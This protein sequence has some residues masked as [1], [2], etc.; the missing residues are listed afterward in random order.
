MYIAFALTSTL[1]YLRGSAREGREIVK[2]EI[3]AYR[4]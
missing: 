2:C 1:D 4:L 3:A